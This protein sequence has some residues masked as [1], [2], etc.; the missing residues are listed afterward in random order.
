MRRKRRA[1]QFVKLLPM[2]QQVV[3]LELVEE[4]LRRQV[5]A[6]QRADE[7]ERVLVGDHVGRRRRQRGRAGGRRPGA[8][9]ASRS[10]GEIGDA[11]GRSSAITSVDCAPPKRSALIACSSSESKVV[12]TK[13]SKSVICASWRERARRREIRVAQDAAHAAC[14]FLAPAVRR[15]EPADDVV[16]RVGLRQLRG[17]DVELGGELLGDPVVEEARAGLGLDLEQLGPDDRDD[18]ALLDE[19]EQVLPRILVERGQRRVHRQQAAHETGF[20]SS[21]ALRSR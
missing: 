16:Q 18:A 1:S 12:V 21:D 10:V 7:F 6:L 13:R 3:V 8:G 19:V 4:L 2:K 5:L 11:V 9:T 15:Q 20:R 17:V 14:R